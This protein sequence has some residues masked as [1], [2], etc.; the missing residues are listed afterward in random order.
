[1]DLQLNNKAALVTGSSKGIGEAIAVALALGRV[2]ELSELADAVAFP[3][4]PA[5]GIHHRHQSPCGRRL[6]VNSL[7]A[8]AFAINTS[9]SAN[10][11]WVIRF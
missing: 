2:G 10:A 6:L 4:E 11:F 3:C 7:K 8:S 1:M 9:G 5:R